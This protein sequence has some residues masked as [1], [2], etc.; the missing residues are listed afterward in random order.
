MEGF[1]ETNF[2]A[3]QSAPYSFSDIV[4]SSNFTLGTISQI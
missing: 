3:I 1:S 4:A 2:S